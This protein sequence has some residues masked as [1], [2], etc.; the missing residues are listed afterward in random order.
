MFWT[1]CIS[2]TDA[3]SK[4]HFFQNTGWW[5]SAETQQSYV[6]TDISV[7]V[8]SLNVCAVIETMTVK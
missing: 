6:P 1:E 4:T 3:V 2:E 7:E 5:A 8:G